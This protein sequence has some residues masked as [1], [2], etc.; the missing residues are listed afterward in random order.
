M[1]LTQDG[2][3]MGTPGYM[4]PEQVRGLAADHRSDIFSFGLV[5]YEMLSGKRA[6]HADTSAET[7]AAILKSDP[8][9]LPGAIPPAVRQAVL[10][11]LEK[12][13]GNR[14]QSASDL[15]FALRNLGGMS[16]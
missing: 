7:M 8:P 10:H 14:F 16:T 2:M 6:F 11:A 3:T 5:L 13:P 15:A 12:E 9:E 1:A 4:A